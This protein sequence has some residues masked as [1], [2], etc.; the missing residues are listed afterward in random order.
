ME[1]L[2]KLTRNKFENFLVLAIFSSI[3]VLI[4]SCIKYIYFGSVNWDEPFQLSS[5][6][7]HLRFGSKVLNG[8]GGNYQDLPANTEWYGVGLKFISVFV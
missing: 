7:D 3:I 8:E 2:N 6:Y 1:F 4:I 5:I